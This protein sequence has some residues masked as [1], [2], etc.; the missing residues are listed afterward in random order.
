MIKKAGL[1]VLLVLMSSVTLFALT[2]AQ[3]HFLKAN[4]FVESKKYSEAIS[5]YEKIIAI[6]PRNTTAHIL[7]GLTYATVGDL[8]QALVYSKKATEIDPAYN[9]FYHLG[10]VQA[11]GKTPD[12]AINTFD[13][14]LK[15]N[16]SSFMAHYQKGVVYITTKNYT[17]AMKSFRESLK[18]NP[19]FDKARLGLV[20]VA[21]KQ[22]NKAEIEEQINELKQLRREDLAKSLKEWLDAN[23]T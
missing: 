23:K 1:I 17:N 7:L 14:A 22:N 19:Q 5:E 20:A 15:A 9:S 4:K 18:L 8:K 11:L 6:E 21:Y 12:Q 10:L 2:E 16:P 3:N 13:K